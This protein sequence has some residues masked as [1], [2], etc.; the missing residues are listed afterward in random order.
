VVNHESKSLAFILANQGY[1]VWLGN[2]RGNKYS[3]IHEQFNPDKNR[4]FWKYSFHE[5]GQYDLPAMI[6]Y[7]RN[8]T[9]KEK[10]FYIGHSQGTAQMFSALTYNIEF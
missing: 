5:M 6:D 4:K 7:I 1:H 8:K 2:N 9:G 3:R 10:I